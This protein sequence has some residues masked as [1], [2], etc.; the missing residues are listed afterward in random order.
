MKKKNGFTTLELMVSIGIVAL[1]TAIAVPSYIS[2]LPGYRLRAAAGDV[3]SAMQMAR[4][5][6]VKENGRVGISFTNGNG[7]NG[8]FTVFVDSDN[9]G[10][11]EPNKDRVV[12]YGEMPGTV[13][14]SSPMAQSIFNG[15]GL[16]T[17]GIGTVRLTNSVGSTKRIQLVTTGSA[18]I[19]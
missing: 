10:I 3:Y 14:L 19:L 9:S 8:K 15:R 6:A 13:S 7:K 5:R 18:R 11:Y 16:V 17:A 12:Q 2:W 4:L 1:L